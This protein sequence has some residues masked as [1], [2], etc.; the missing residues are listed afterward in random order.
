MSGK[1]NFN[2]IA[3]RTAFNQAKV[4]L[5][6]NQINMFEYRSLCNNLLSEVKKMDENYNNEDVLETLNNLINKEKDITPK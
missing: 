3:I 4:L 6:E 1:T 5:K 2:Y